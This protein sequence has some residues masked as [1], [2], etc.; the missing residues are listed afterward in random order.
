MVKNLTIRDHFHQLIKTASVI[1]HTHIVHLLLEAGVDLVALGQRLL[2]LIKLL[3]VEGQLWRRERRSEA[4]SAPGN[5]P[6]SNRKLT[7]REGAPQC[8]R[9]VKLQVRR[10]LVAVQKSLSSDGGGGV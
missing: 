1:I 2:E 6:G 5:D 10:C 7:C 9:A 3:S 8:G 4:V